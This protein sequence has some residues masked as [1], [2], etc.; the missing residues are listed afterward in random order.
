M[1]KISPPRREFLIRLSSVSAVLATGATLSACG[2]GTD[3]VVLFNYGVASGD[4]LTDRVILWTHA[5]FEQSTDDVQLTY[6]VATDNNFS[7]VVSSGIATASAS[8]NYTVK[9]GNAP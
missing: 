8:N 4:P 3:P 1:N 5:T 6:Q 7:S 9:V 2:N